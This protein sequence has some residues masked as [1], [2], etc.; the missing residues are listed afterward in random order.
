[1]GIV[2]IGEACD[3]NPLLTVTVCC[4]ATWSGVTPHAVNMSNKDAQQTL[5]FKTSERFLCITYLSMRMI[6]FSQNKIDFLDIT[7]HSPARMT[8]SGTN[9]KKNCNIS[10]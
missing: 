9:G 8:Q 4:G 10:E 1:V 5:N 6:S 3:W 7:T 2:G